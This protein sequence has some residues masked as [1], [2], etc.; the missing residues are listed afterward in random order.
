M[1][2]ATNQAAEERVEPEPPDNVT[3]KLVACLRA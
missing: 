3:G 1:F 2:A